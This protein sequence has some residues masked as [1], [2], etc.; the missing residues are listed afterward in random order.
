M[1]WAA[2]GG[3]PSY[4]WRSPPTAAPTF[5]F[6]E[7]CKVQIFEADQLGDARTLFMQIQKVLSLSN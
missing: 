2:A 6:P 4:C 3:L 1:G 7:L 5:L